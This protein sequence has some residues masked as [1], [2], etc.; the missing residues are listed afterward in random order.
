MGQVTSKT[1]ALILTNQTDDPRILTLTPGM[2]VAQALAEAGIRSEST[3]THPD[4][5]HSLSPD[6]DLFSLCEDGDKLKVT[7]AFTA[8]AWWNPRSWRHKPAQPVAAQPVAVQ[9]VVVSTPTDERWLR[10]YGWLRDGNAWR[11]FF[12]VGGRPPI[13][14][15]IDI[16]SGVP[17]ACFENPPEAVQRHIC[18]H[19]LQNAVGWFWVNE[20]GAVPGRTLRGFATSVESWL[21]KLLN[22]ASRV[23]PA[24]NS[25]PPARSAA[26]RDPK[27]KLVNSGGTW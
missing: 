4:G 8:G 12:R 6:E 9:P 27:V 23:V 21:E 1:V 26:A 19:R 25:Q 11:G 5:G 20:H 18:V 3:M 15:Y 7:P 14:A 22:P 17:R 24:P 16:E 2:T 13:R 10:R